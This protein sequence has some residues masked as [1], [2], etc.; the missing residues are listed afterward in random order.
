MQTNYFKI[1]RSR[2]IDD[3]A[4]ERHARKAW[5]YRQRV[6]AEVIASMGGKCVK[7]GFSDP[8]ALQIDHIHGGGS[9]E[10]QGGSRYALF[11]RLSKH[12]D[13]IKFQLLCANCNTIK[14]E[15]NGEQTKCRKYQA[16]DIAPMWEP[17]VFD[18]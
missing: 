3:A 13:P 6:R 5:A 17:A 8:R 15:E 10:E 2:N 12:P 14:R 7:C 4:R 16:P 1:W 9:Q 18:F 11:A